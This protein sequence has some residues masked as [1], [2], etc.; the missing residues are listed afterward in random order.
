[1]SRRVDFVINDY[2]GHPFQIELSD[3]LAIQGFFVTHAFCSTNVTPRGDLDRGSHNLSVVGISTGEGFDKYNAFRRLIAEV[4]Y[5]LGSAR[6]LYRDRPEAALHSNVPIVSLLMASIVCRAL[7][8]RNVLW[9][10]DVQAGLVALALGGSHPITR[11]LKAVERWC[12]RNADHVVAI[13][14]GFAREVVAMGVDSSTIT[15]IPNWAPLD[16]MP[17]RERQNP[18]AIENGIGVDG[19]VLLYSGT[20]GIKH[21]PEA[22]I[23]AAEALSKSNP[24]ATIVVVSEGV[25]ADWLREES[26]KRSLT[27]FRFFPFQ[28]FDRLPEVLA[29]ADAL[30]VLLEPDAGEFSVPSKALTYL[31]AARPIVGLMPPN[32]GASQL[33]AHDAD[34]GLVA[35]TESEFVSHVLRLFEDSSLRDAFAVKARNYAE[36]EF[37]RPRIASRFLPVLRPDQPLRAPS[38]PPKSEKVKAAS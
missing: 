22:L 6:V 24:A 17:Q 27:N 26:T 38:K 2:A 9:L 32:N 36:R 11:V 15:T 3:E 7:R 10:Q 18:W 12:I 35:S 20:M 30:V 14:E 5:G 19:P 28:P 37:N 21:R 34:A 29:S 33:V 31:C 4:R 13:S 1:M 8:V 25:G 23:A 16:D